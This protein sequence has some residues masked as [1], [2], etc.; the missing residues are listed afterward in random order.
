MQGLGF[1]GPV[2]AGQFI[3]GG[4]GADSNYWETQTPPS[5]PR[6]L[7]A[8]YTHLELPSIDS[9]KNRK[10]TPTYRLH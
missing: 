9:E 1:T 6:S 5:N 4:G 3:G 2:R 8:S 7:Y 10:H